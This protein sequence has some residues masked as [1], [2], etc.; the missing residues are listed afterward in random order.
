MSN[1]KFDL[2]HKLKYKKT[3]KYYDDYDDEEVNERPKNQID[4]RKAR[5]IERALKTKDIDAL[6]EDE[7]LDDFEEYNSSF[8]EEKH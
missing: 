1:T 4:K 3:N 2:S 8:E 7:E 6:L 5:R